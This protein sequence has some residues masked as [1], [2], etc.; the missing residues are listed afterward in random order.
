MQ[1]PSRNSKSSRLFIPL[2]IPNLLRNRNTLKSS[3][4][5]ALVARGGLPCLILKNV[6]GLNAFVG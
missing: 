3:C 4:A 5:G 6:P 1:V 2:K